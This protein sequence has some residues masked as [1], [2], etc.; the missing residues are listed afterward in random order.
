[1]HLPFTPRACPGVPAR[2]P[3]ARLR[4]TE[5]EDRVTPVFPGLRGNFLLASTYFPHTLAPAAPVRPVTPVVPPASLGGGTGAVI[6]G[7]GAG[8]RLTAPGTGLIGNG[9][10]TGTGL[11]GVGRIGNGTGI[12]TVT[13]PGTG[14]AGP[15][16]P[17]GGTGLIGSGSGVG[18][19]TAP[20]TGLG[21]IGGPTV[22]IAP[23]LIPIGTGGAGTT[24]Q[25][26]APGLGGATG[27]GLTGLSGTGFTGT[28]G[29][30]GTGL[31][32]GVGLP[33][34]PVAG[35]PGLFGP[36]LGPGLAASPISSATPTGP[37]FTNLF[38]PATSPAGS[39]FDR[40]PS[41]VGLF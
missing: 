6:G 31:T 30:D 1:M 34:A 28:G 16:T 12:G 8:G 26:G 21:G 38:P 27:T 37:A 22:G 11:P 23:P 24:G 7:A 40:S 41:V 29:L 15:G 9:L 20:G 18:T 36:D 35:S 5:C 4:L 19:V 32:T 17:V 25:P 14:S 2:R 39:A 33:S 3:A 13:A 10:P